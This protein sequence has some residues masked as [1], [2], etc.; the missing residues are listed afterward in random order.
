[1]FLLDTLL[2]GGLRF[3]LDK[4]A[5]AA[6]QELDDVDRLREELLAAQMRVELGEMREEDFA[7]FERDILSRM[8]AI[9]EAREGE[10]AT[11]V[12]GKRGTLRVTGVE[13]TFGGDE[14]EP[15]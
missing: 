8:R 4:V 14:D 15:K 6:E 9:R 7:D 2:I 1:M 12:V 5:S 13:A 10:T 3:V 11:G